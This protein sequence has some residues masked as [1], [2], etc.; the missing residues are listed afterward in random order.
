MGSTTMPAL[1]TNVQSH[2][3][4]AVADL[5]DATGF[6]LSYRIEYASTDDPRLAGTVLDVTPAPGATLTDG[7]EIAFTV[8]AAD[9]TPIDSEP[10]EAEIV[11]GSAPQGLRAAAAQQPD[12]RPFVPWVR[13]L[14][15]EDAFAVFTAMA[16]T[17]STEGLRLGRQV[18]PVDDVRSHGRIV[19]VEPEELTALSPGD[20][21]MLTIGLFDRSA[22]SG[23]PPVPDMPAP[24]PPCPDDADCDGLSDARELQLAREFVPVFEF[25][26]DEPSFLLPPN[27]GLPYQVTPV[28][29]DDTN[30]PAVLLTYL[31]MY[32]VDC[33]DIRQVSGEAAAI[34]ATGVGLLAAAFGVPVAVAAIYGG[35]SQADPCGPGAAPQQ[36]WW[37]W[38]DTELYRVLVDIP[39]CR[40][41]LITSG[42]PTEVFDRC[43][44][45]GHPAV[46]AVEI[47][48][49]GHRF[50]YRHSEF[51]RA[52]DVT[53]G[54]GAI[55]G[56]TNVRV[57]V[58]NSKH[59]GFAGADE[60]EAA[61]I[62]DVAGVT[63][64]RENCAGGFVWEP[65]L[66]LTADLNVGEWHHQAFTVATERPA[67]AHFGD[68]QIW[69]HTFGRAACL[70]L[71]CVA[72]PIKFC[73]GNEHRLEPGQSR[74]D[75]WLQ[76]MVPVCA[77]AVSKF[78][79]P[80]NDQ[81]YDDA[82]HETELGDSP[83]YA[84]SMAEVPAGDEAPSDTLMTV[85]E[86]RDAA[87]YA[88]GQWCDTITELVDSGMLA[89]AQSAVAEG[90]VSGALPYDRAVA[91]AVGVYLERMTGLGE[92]L[93]PDAAA[94]NDDVL[95][96]VINARSASL[97]VVAAAESGD[98]DA[99][100][101]EAT[102]AQQRGVEL[103]EALQRHGLDA[104]C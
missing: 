41:M 7:T 29:M 92:L 5:A 20:T 99:Y 37:H 102:A 50:L 97:A 47:Q 104:S 16:S 44:E 103:F 32:S 53:G 30:A 90:D 38:G 100:R 95:R 80:E 51:D 58:S 65:A 21:V 68:E 66:D 22:V 76:G 71:D 88:L 28:T 42:D 31:V 49:H 27:L 4:A 82:E 63:S 59:A 9:L 6:D 73:G 91:D 85:G 39:E 48:R 98:I 83:L 67:L 25:D 23:G 74:D 75:S 17:T 64:G 43:R 8:A 15:Y 46:A 87:D 70:G 54:A 78:W 26:Q 93:G 14:T 12:A 11:L 18:R 79:F 69:D 10:F 89:D 55:S 60:C 35:V 94:I 13:G 52:E 3:P 57:Y 86:Y 56:N 34:G 77:G 81:R 36:I 101:R 61:S 45:E 84:V 96:Y 62:Q 1:L 24:E 72:D 33:L 19:D 40:N 2:I